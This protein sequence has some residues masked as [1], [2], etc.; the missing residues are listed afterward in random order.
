[1]GAFEDLQAALEARRLRTE[2]EYQQMSRPAQLAWQGVRGVAGLP[3]AVVGL[4]GLLSYL[5]G[6]A[7]GSDTLRN[8]GERYTQ[9]VTQ[10]LED[11]TSAVVGVPPPNDV[12][13]RLVSIGT[14]AL[15]PGAPL[16]TSSRSLR[17]LHSIL[18]PRTQHYTPAGIATNT[19]VPFAIGEGVR[20]ALGLESV[21]TPNAAQAAP[22][23]ASATPDAQSTDPFVLP[24]V[25]GG[26]TREDPFVL[27]APAAQTVDPFVLPPT[28]QRRNPLSD[29]L[30]VV[31]NPAVIAGAA[32]LG[33]GAAALRYTQS[34]RRLRTPVEM[35]GPVTA[36]PRADQTVNTVGDAVQGAVVDRNRPMVNLVERVAGDPTGFRTMAGVYGNPNAV[37]QRIEFAA[38]EGKL[39]GDGGA[40]MPVPPRVMYD[41]FTAL[42]PGQQEQ[43]SRGLL[44]ADA[45]D[46]R[47]VVLRERLTEQATARGVSVDELDR[48]LVQEITDRTRPSYRNLDNSALERM[49]QDARADS[50]VAELMNTFQQNTRVMLDHMYNNGLFTKDQYEWLVRNRSNYVP[51]VLADTRT[52]TER[53][54]DQLRL[55]NVDKTEQQM[56]EG[57]QALLQRAPH[58]VAGEETLRLDPMRAFDQTFT[59]IQKF[60]ANNNMRNAFLDHVLSKGAIEREPRLGRLIRKTEGGTYGDNIVSVMRRGEQVR[61]EVNDPSLLYS[62][63]LNP[64][65]ANSVWNWTRRLSQ[66]T[67]TGKLNPLWTAS[68]APIM[69]DAPLAMLTRPAGTAAGLFEHIALKYGVQNRFIGDPT[70]FATAIAGVGIGGYGHVLR[71]ARNT[72]Q[73]ALENN[74]SLVSMLG[75]PE[76]ASKWFTRVSDAY[77]RSTVAMFEEFGMGSAKFMSD[78]ALPSFRS[79]ARVVSPELNAPLSTLQRAWTG[80]GTALEVVQNG[81]RYGYL[82]LN[83]ER[84]QNK[85]LLAFYTRQLTGDFGQSGSNRA[86]RA[87]T[88][89]SPYANVT[90]QSLNR[91]VEAGQADFVGMASRLATGALLPMATL[92]MSWMSQ[93]PN[94][95]DYWSRLSDFDQTSYIRIPLPGVAPEHSPAVAIEPTLRPAY[96]ALIHGLDMMF[97]FTSGMFAQAHQL[98]RAVDGLTG[99][100]HTERYWS[101]L[102]SMLMPQMPPLVT[103]GAALAGYDTRMEFGEPPL[104][105][106]MPQQVRSHQVGDTEQRYVDDIISQRLENAIVAFTGTLGQMSVDML[107]AW[108][109]GNRA[110]G[111]YVDAASGAAERAEVDAMR[112]LRVF[113]GLLWQQEA[114]MTTRTNEKEYLDRKRDAMRILSNAAN[115]VAAYGATGT[116]PA[117]QM[118]AGQRPTIG[119]TGPDDPL[120]LVINAVSRFSQQLN[121]DPMLEQQVSVLQ[122]QMNRVMSD[123]NRSPSQREADRNQYARRIQDIHRQMVDRIS[124]FE[125][126]LSIALGRPVTLEEFSGRVHSVASQPSQSPSP[127]Q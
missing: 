15:V 103:A 69:Y 1:M 16:A 68:L 101:S 97:G 44:A 80:Y 122:N 67:Q 28:D 58:A 73:R 4:P 45:L 82:W 89:A 64:A 26:A 52:L 41:R 19:A 43:L 37:A 119:V 92:Y 65:Y 104:R 21:F 77:A 121:S 24:P 6:V 114:R 102:S 60:I 62:L 71:A 123:Q 57:L 20:G 76:N 93:S 78:A 109:W 99:N 120:P 74:T 96:A 34:L 112:R 75:G 50:R 90:I 79:V 59:S 46:D 81:M 27:S 10:P 113:N 84:V 12:T 88:A 29:V 31:L 8:F 106:S 49:V 124:A 48:G 42:E 116:G 85:E 55:I 54:L 2:Q 13:E 117:A 105:P 9:N 108:T 35:D 118:S 25:T 36:T 17:V 66:T 107:R 91:L 23:G 94:H 11:F 53:T 115:L 30:D 127:A 38:S 83:R 125:D 47:R 32:V 5:T 100:S 56:F 3:A 33:G 18:D 61:Y 110:T 87:A 40:R 39:L 51:H 70:S 95:Q 14:S 7:T 126:Q 22:P 63:K 111:S 98:Q 86:V 72:L